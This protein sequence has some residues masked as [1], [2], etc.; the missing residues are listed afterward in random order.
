MSAKSRRKRRK[1]EYDFDVTTV[2]I[3]R[4][5]KDHVTRHAHYQESFD[6]TLR[7]LLKFDGPKQNGARSDETA[8]SR[9]AGAAAGR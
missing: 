2:R 7:R 9:K 3:S 6:H 4:A 5:L 1:T 8:K